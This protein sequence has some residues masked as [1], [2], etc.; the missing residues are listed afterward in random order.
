MPIDK[1]VGSFD[2]AVADVFDGATIL[3]GGMGGIAAA[4]NNLMAALART[5]VKNLTIVG[6]GP[7]MGKFLS[8]AMLTVRKLPDEWEDASK[9]IE[10]KQVRKMIVSVPGMAITG[11]THTA[12]F[13][14]EAA[15]REGQDIELELVGQ[16]T[17]SE[18][19]RAARAGIPAFY[20][21]AGV[22]TYLARGKEV[23]AFDGK[24]Y[25]LERALKGD[26]ALIYA[27]KADRFGNLVYRGTARMLNSTMAGAATVTIAEVDHLVEPGELNP[28]A[29]VTPAVYVN[30]I[31]VRPNSQIR[32]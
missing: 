4:A 31:V 20:T 21:P 18:R 9:L 3:V 8:Q 28:E 30:R 10:N 23:R 14:I 11:M 25:V 32:V 26:F 12:L 19:C 22:G 6:N 7:A 17:L 13:P 5:K 1:V 29:V 27:H 15:L 16:G 24:E 2:E